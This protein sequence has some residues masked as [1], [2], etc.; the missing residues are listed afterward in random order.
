M[1][2]ANLLGK[3]QGSRRDADTD[4]AAHNLRGKQEA[5]LR[6]KADNHCLASPPLNFC[7]GGLP[8]QAGSAF[9]PLLQAL[10]QAAAQLTKVDFQLVAGT[11]Q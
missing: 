1:L 8:L 4:L 7:V 3:V 11:A 6:F 10:Q 5:H 2:S 9:G